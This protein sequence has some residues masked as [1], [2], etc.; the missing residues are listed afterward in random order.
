[1]DAGWGAAATAALS[2]LLW[3]LNK[4]NSSASARN[5]KEIEDDDQRLRKE[6]ESLDADAIS[7]RIDRVLNPSSHTPRVS[8]NSSEEGASG[9]K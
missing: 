5:Q 7:G 6:C 9:P 4:W 2:I 3:L 1:M 8:N